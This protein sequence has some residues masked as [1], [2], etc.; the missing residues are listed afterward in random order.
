MLIK[1]TFSFW[2]IASLL[3]A[4]DKVAVQ[5]LHFVWPVSMNILPNVDKEELG[6]LLSGFGD[7]GGP[8]VTVG[9]Y[10]FA[11]LDD[12]APFLIATTDAS[13]RGFFNGLDILRCVGDTCWVSYLFSDEPNDLAAQIVD[14]SEDG[15]KAIVTQSLVHWAGAKT[16]P[17]YVFSIMKRQGKEFVDVTG[18]YRQFYTDH[19]LNRDPSGDKAFFS[20]ALASKKSGRALTSN[21]PDLELFEQEEQFRLDYYDRHVLGVK[22][23]GLGHASVWSKSSDRSIVTLAIRALGDIGTK[24]ALEELARVAQRPDDLGER[25]NAELQEAVGKVGKR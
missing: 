7:P 14:V 22:D 23:A 9:E 17:V 25:A 5:V 2:A 11:K 19:L 13:G 8:P 21:V 18:K 12:E 15:H 6:R 24:P 20:E 16:L 4:D 3:A 10:S 1:A